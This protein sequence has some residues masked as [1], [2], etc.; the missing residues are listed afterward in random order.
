MR[1]AS[2][3]LHRHAGAL[4]RDVGRPGAVPVL[5]GSFPSAGAAK[6]W[7]AARPCP[8]Q[9]VANGPT[10]GARAGPPLLPSV[11]SLPRSSFGFP[12]CGPH[13][14]PLM[15]RV[16][17]AMDRNWR[18]MPAVCKRTPT[19]CSRQSVAGTSAFCFIRW[20]GSA[21]TRISRRP[22][23]STW[24]DFPSGKSSAGWVA[25]ETRRL[26]G[27]RRVRFSAKP[28][29]SRESAGPQVGGGVTAIA[30]TRT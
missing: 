3:R 12:A 18:P 20:P 16:S 6:S 4:G 27:C 2:G 28:L 9:I 14:R 26:P 29:S 11:A 22:S 8:P 19:K 25:R 7:L 10:T 5:Q 13:S 15:R 17:T 23:S 30:A 21:I 24:H 1:L